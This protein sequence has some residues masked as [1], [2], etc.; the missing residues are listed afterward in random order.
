MEENCR[1]IVPL[2]KFVSG[3]ESV[4]NVEISTKELARTPCIIFY[5]GFVQKRHGVIYE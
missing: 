1:N 4:N 2:L 3:C 5:H